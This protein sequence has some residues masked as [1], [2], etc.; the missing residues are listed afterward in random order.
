M[1]LICINQKHVKSLLY[2]YSFSIC[3]AVIRLAVETERD[4]VEQNEYYA[5][6][7]Q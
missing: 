5:F 2:M 6:L 3:H 1:N 7:D 4:T